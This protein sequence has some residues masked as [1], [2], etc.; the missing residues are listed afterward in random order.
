M[1]T[2]LLSVKGIFFYQKER[3]WYYRLACRRK[4]ELT[5]HESH[6]VVNKRSMTLVNEAL[7]PLFFFSLYLN[8]KNDN[9]WLRENVNKN[10]RNTRTTLE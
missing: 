10:A 3:W 1:T 4:I 5:V 7:A 9:C 6:H 2:K 8:P